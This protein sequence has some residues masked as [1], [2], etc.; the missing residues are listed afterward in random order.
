MYQHGKHV[1]RV[2]YI[3][4]VDAREA[5]KDTFTVTTDY[6]YLDDCT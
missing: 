2:N 1:P 3:V 5:P 6:L 4:R